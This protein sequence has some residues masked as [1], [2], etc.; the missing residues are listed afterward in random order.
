MDAIDV[1][2]HTQGQ[3][4][5]EWHGDIVNDMIADAVVAVLLRIESHPVSVKLTKSAHHHHE[6]S[7][8]DKN[9]HHET[10]DEII[11]IVELCLRSHFSELEDKE[12]SCQLSVDRSKYEISFTVDTHQV[13]IDLNNLGVECQD[14]DVRKRI[15]SILQELVLTLMPLGHPWEL[16][17]K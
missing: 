10:R 3:L 7:A 12:D 2:Q 1:R 8:E 6:E 9:F 13:M 16:P 17:N 5:L 14:E 11:D 15:E 4:V